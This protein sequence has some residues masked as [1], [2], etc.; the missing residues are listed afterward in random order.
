MTVV[1]AV[2]SFTATGFETVWPHVEGVF[3][4]I[5][6]WLS[7]NSEKIWETIG[8]ALGAVGTWLS[9]TAWPAIMAAAVAIGTW[10]GENKEAV[11]NSIKSGLEVLGEFIS[12]TLWPFLKEIAAP[13]F[14]TNLLNAFGL[15]GDLFRVLSKDISLGDFVKSVATRVFNTSRNI[16]VS[17]G[18]ALS[19]LSDDEVIRNNAKISNEVNAIVSRNNA[20]FLGGH[21]FLS[22]DDGYVYVL[23]SKVGSKELADL[24]AK[25]VIEGATSAMF[26]GYGILNTHNGIPDS[27]ERVGRSDTAAAVYGGAAE[28]GAGSYQIKSSNPGGVINVN[29]AIVTS[30]GQV[31]HTS[32]EDNIYAF[33]GDVQIAPANQVREFSGSPVSYNNSQSSS[34]SNVTNN[35]INNSNFNLADLMPASE[36]DPVGV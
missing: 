1:K 19:E 24:E 11:W 8:A 35:Y 30:D 23:P 20:K 13:F 3:R 12:K 16:T 29:D 15:V 6:G 33:K 17:A 27:A 21:F 36:F 5:G 9:G 2:G 34:S 25:G 31:I 14:I 7:A 18:A 28:D 26:G 10:V 4:A 22:P 32:P